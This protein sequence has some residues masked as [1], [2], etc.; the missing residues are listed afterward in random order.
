MV[1]V[2]NVSE[3]NTCVVTPW[4]HHPEKKKKK[5]KNLNPQID[6]IL[7]KYMLSSCLKVADK[8]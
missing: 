6:W 1:L 8:T 7:E 3:K 2:P 4:Q 5:K